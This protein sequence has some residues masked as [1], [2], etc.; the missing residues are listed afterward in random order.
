MKFFV[1]TYILIWLKVKPIW[2]MLVFIMQ[3]KSSFK[4]ASD[5]S[6]ECNKY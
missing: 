2:E 1:I 6:E 3:L 5:F 4:K